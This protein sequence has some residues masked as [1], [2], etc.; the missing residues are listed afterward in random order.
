METPLS[1]GLSDV[2]AST[3]LQGRSTAFIAA[4]SFTLPHEGMVFED[5]P[6]DDGG[7]TA[8]G[9][10]QTDFDS[11]LSEHGANGSPVSKITPGQICRVYADH[12]WTPLGCES[13]QFPVA[14]ALFDT[15]VN[16]GNSESIKFL[17]RELGVTDDGA[18][19]PN[20]LAAEHAYVVKHGAIALATGIIAFRR[21]FYQELAEEHANDAQFEVGWQSRCTDLQ[22]AISAT[23]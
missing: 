10:T 9:I 15:G 20:T 1:F 18:M 2:I 6:G 5:V 21:V 17:Q 12:Y 13:F 11:W 4:L 8:A 23:A 22:S 19:G 14:L 16:C 7:A 3:H